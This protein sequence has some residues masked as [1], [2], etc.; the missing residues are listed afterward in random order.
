VNVLFRKQ[1]YSLFRSRRPSLAVIARITK[2]M[3][4][5]LELRSSLRHVLANRCSRG[6]RRIPDASG[7]RECVSTVQQLGRSLALP[8]SQSS[9]TAPLAKTDGHRRPLAN[10]QLFSCTENK[11]SMAP[12]RYCQTL[13]WNAALAVCM[14]V[15]VHGAEIS[16]PVKV[17]ILAG[18][19]KRD[20]EG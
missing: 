3:I 17:F 19:S 7:F 9:A 1:E 15:S 10:Q 6:F 4:S 8:T 13:I 18:Q 12:Q 11:T 20:T 14:S 16:K 2:P 5:C